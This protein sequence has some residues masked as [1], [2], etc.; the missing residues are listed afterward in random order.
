MLTGRRTPNRGVSPCFPSSTPTSGPAML[1]H[2]PCGI[3]GLP[4]MR[5]PMNDSHLFSPVG[6]QAALEMLLLR[7]PVRLKCHPLANYHYAGRCRGPAGAHCL[8]VARVPFTNREHPFSPQCRLFTLGLWGV[9]PLPQWYRVRVSGTAG[10]TV[11]R[12]TGSQCRARPQG[13]W[14]GGVQPGSSAL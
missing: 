3:V 4:R 10:R 11:G 1:A 7:K 2:L 9:A 5:S 13:Q 12:E 8:H 14:G 6:L